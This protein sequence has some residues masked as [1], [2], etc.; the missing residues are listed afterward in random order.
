MSGFNK[1]KDFFNFAAFILSDIFC[2]ECSLFLA[3]ITRYSFGYHFGNSIY[4]TMAVVIVFVYFCVLFFSQAYKNILTRGYLEEFINTLSTTFMIMLV[5]LLYTFLTQTSQDYSRIIVALFPIYSLILIYVARIILKKLLM[6]K[7]KHTKNRNIVTVITT[8]KSAYKLIKQQKLDAKNYI[9]SFV[10]V[11]ED[12]KG[13]TIKSIPVVANRFSVDS[14]LLLNRV[15]EVFLITSNDIYSEFF[16][17][18]I[19]QMCD[20]MGIVLHKTL[21]NEPLA[22]GYSV[23]NILGYT[24]L[25][26]NIVNMSTRDIIVKRFFDIIGGLIGCLFTLILI[27]IIGPIIY[28]SSPG[29]IFFSQNRVGRNGKVFKIYKFR[30]MYLD[31]EE[32]K[33]ELLKQNKVKDGMMFKIDKDPRIIKGIGSFIRKTSIDEFPQFLNILKGDMSLVGT[34]PPTIDEWKKYKAHHKKRLAIKPGLT[35]MWQ[36]SGR[37]NITDF[38]E[39]VKLDT[40]Y[41]ANFSL[42]LDL[43]ILVK[44]FLV[45]F[46]KEGSA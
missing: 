31:A 27:I 4:Q 16:Y 23:N 26:H 41:I 13:K 33:K 32:R 44:T 18:E 35:G 25:S 11:D 38:E 21:Y 24:V 37:S 43:K 42:K 20:K 17:D 29:N 14:Y 40:T 6:T 36:I 7:H 30:S 19:E 10:I 34:R 22:E 3:Y 2:I 9:S 5:F 8:K 1:R 46:K 45:V 15:D 12:L 28:F 39:V